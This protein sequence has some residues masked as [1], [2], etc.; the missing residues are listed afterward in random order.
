MRFLYNGILHCRS[1]GSTGQKAMRAWLE[2]ATEIVAQLHPKTIPHLTTREV[3]GGGRAGGKA[4]L[5]PKTIPHLTTLQKAAAR[6]SYTLLHI[7]IGRFIG[8]VSPSKI[9]AGAVQPDL[10]PDIR[11]PAIP[12][13]EVPG[14]HLQKCRQAQTE[15]SS[16]SAQR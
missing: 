3:Q 7:A 6:L 10:K 11:L 2:V 16:L 14:T 8:I 1:L 12:A 5:H 15:N 4:Q 9:F 13:D